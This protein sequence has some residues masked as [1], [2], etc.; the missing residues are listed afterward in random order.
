MPKRCLPRD[1]A[2]EKDVQN[3]ISPITLYL[4]KLEPRFKDQNSY[5]LENTIRYLSDP[6]GQLGENTK[7]KMTIFLWGTYLLA[8]MAIFRHVRMM[9]GCEI[10]NQ[11]IKLPLG[12][13]TPEK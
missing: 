8:P 12:A 1:E 6:Y 7:G 9:N 3:A 5:G 13:Q 11:R 10:Q 2:V 4:S